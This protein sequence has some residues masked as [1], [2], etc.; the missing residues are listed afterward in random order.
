MST[1]N[2]K[3]EIGDLG[4]VVCGDSTESELEQLR[5]I[6]LDCTPFKN[7]TMDYLISKEVTYSERIKTL[8]SILNKTKR[9]NFEKKTLSEINDIVGVRLV[10]QNLTD[11]KLC[12]RRL[13][14]KETIVHAKDMIKNPTNAG[15]SAIHL[16]SMVDGKIVEI[17]IK[18]QLLNEFGTFMHDRLY[19]NKALLGDKKVQAYLRAVNRHIL[20]IENG[21][22]NQTAPTPPES[23]LKEGLVFSCEIPALIELKNSKK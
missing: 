3:H 16:F 6:F 13:I 12:V 17:Q 20:E 5:S 22:R 7:E 8:S 18:T 10:A 2:P 15:Y 9:I 4:D 14:E 11:V 19:K 23:L 21:S 1:Q